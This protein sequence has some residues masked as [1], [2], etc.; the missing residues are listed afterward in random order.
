MTVAELI[1]EL[2]DINGELPVSFARG[3]QLK[4]IDYEVVCDGRQCRIVEVVLG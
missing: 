2:S 4:S 3:G 1:E